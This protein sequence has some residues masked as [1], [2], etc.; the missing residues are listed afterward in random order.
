[1]LQNSPVTFWL[2]CLWYQCQCVHTSIPYLAAL[3]IVNLVNQTHKWLTRTHT[4][5]MEPKQQTIQSSFPNHLP[6]IGRLENHIST[7]LL[8]SE[9]I[10]T[11][12]VKRTW[13]ST[14]FHVKQWG[15]I[16]VE[17]HCNVVQYNRVFAYITA[18]TETE[19]KSHF[20][21][22]KYIPSLIIMGELW[23]V[24]VRIWEIDLY[25][26]MY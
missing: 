26:A 23:D 15:I 5:N 17:C 13:T 6:A 14:Y 12:I 22:T 4:D 1:M 19:H 21:S 3:Y 2:L 20:Q 18:V 8:L 9:I 10:L 24:F 7:P 11:N 25:L 16:R